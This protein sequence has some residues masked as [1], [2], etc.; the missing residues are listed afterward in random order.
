MKK[1]LG[2]LCV[3]GTPHGATIFDPVIPEEA[4]NAPTLKEFGKR[5]GALAILEH[6]RLIQ[7][8]CHDEK[9]RPIFTESLYQFFYE[10]LDQY[11]IL[12]YSRNPWDAPLKNLSNLYTLVPFM[13]DKRPTP[14]VSDISCRLQDW[15]HSSNLLE[16]LP[17]L[18]RKIIRFWRMTIPSGLKGPLEEAMRLNPNK[19]VWELLTKMPL[20]RVK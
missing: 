15:I 4:K 6:A 3:L 7:N 9:E 13:W 19:E 1:V 11:P 2:M 20:V 10:D 14:C 17:I 12:G 18:Q 8:L 5:G 16:M